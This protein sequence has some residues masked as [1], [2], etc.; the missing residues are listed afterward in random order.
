MTI[1]AFNRRNADDDLVGVWKLDTEQTSGH[2]PCTARQLWVIRHGT[3][4]IVT[5][6]GIDHFELSLDPSSSPKVFDVDSWFQPVGIYEIDG[7]TL[8]ICRTIAQLPRPAD[9]NTKLDDLRTV[10][11]L[12]R[13]EADPR[14]SKGELRDLF[15]SEFGPPTEYTKFD[16]DAE[17][18]VYSIV[19][20]SPRKWSEKRTIV[21]YTVTFICEVNNGGL[22]QYL[23][24]VWGDTAVETASFLRRVG[25][26][27]TARLLED[28]CKLFP[29]GTVP[30]DHQDRRD[31]LEQFTPTQLRT[32]GQLTEQF[33]ARK[34]DLYVLLK[35][36]WESESRR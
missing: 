24:N 8:R 6:D 27:E 23:Y 5:D 17:D 11:I 25:A 9:F 4:A 19:R 36:Y 2:P 35:T 10:S 26:P 31:Q 14:M 18:F 16:R 12:Q 33:Y 32:L 20:K 28:A 29:G 22:H 34:E 1:L 21:D 13:L 3:L 7:D 15:Q 30:Q